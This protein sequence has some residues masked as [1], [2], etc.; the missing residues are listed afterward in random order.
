MLIIINGQLS[1]AKTNRSCYYLDL[2]ELYLLI[3]TSY[4]SSKNIKFTAEHEHPHILI[5]HIL[6][7]ISAITD[8]LL[9]FLFSS[10]QHLNICNNGKH[11]K[12][13][14]KGENITLILNPPILIKHQVFN[15]A[16]SNKNRL[17]LF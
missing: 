16:P 10:Y 8:E 17:K 6:T 12:D 4:E 1:Q 13:E 5:T 2:D 11:K 9:I 7:R 15:V 14:C 3:P